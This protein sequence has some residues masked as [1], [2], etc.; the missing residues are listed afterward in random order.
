MKILQKY[1]NDDFKDIKLIISIK[2]QKETLI[3]KEK[4]YE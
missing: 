1:K 2:T 3:L 4:V